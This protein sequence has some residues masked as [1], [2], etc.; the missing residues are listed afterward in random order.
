M[1]RGVETVTLLETL[2]REY[3]TRPRIVLLTSPFQRRADRK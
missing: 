2:D 3:R 1:K